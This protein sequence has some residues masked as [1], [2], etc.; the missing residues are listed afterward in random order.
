MMNIFETEDLHGPHTYQMFPVVI[1]R[2]VDHGWFR[3]S[4]VRR[5]VVRAYERDLFR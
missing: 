4:S 5:E 1:V 2:G 3:E